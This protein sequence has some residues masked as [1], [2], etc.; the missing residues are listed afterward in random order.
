MKTFLFIIT[1]LFLTVSAIATT[2]TTTGDGN[3]NNA[4]NW[5]ANGSPGT[6][7]GA[8][9]I[10]IINNV[11]TLNV[12]IGYAGSL[13]INAGASLIGN[14]NIS[15]NNGG[16]F[17]ADGEVSIKKL[18]LNS[19]SSM[20]H[21]EPLTTSSD[22]TVGTN[23]TLTSN[24]EVVIGGKL[25]NNGGIIIANDTYDI[26]GNLT[27]NNG[28]I[29]FNEPTTV[30]GKFDNNNSSAVINLNSTFDVTG[31]ITN[32][33]SATINIDSE[34]VVS[35]SGNFTNNSG[36]QVNNDG[37][38]NSSGNFKNNGGTIDSNGIV[39]ID[40]SFTQNG[41]TFSNNGG[42]IVD[43]GFTINGGGTV[44]GDGI[45]RVD[46]ITNHGTFTG[47]VDICRQD[48]STPTTTS[49]SGSYNVAL[50][51]CTETSS[52]AL[53]IILKNFS[54]VYISNSTIEVTWVTSSEINN[55]YFT[56]F[57]SREGT[58]FVKAKTINAAGNNNTELTYKTLI[59]NNESNELYLQLK[60][61]DFDGNF[62]IFDPILVKKELNIK[63]HNSEEVSIFPNP[64]DG[65]T[66]FA[67]F[68]NFK[69]D[70]YQIHI[71]DNNGRLIVNN[72]V[73]IEKGSN[74]LEVELLNGIR[75]EK[76]LHFIRVSS[77]NYVVTRKY[78]VY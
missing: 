6:Y 71:L 37:R 62:E 19:T 16:S 12:N 2:Y 59:E 67:E 68:K 49:G 44:N 54:A 65:A 40:G 3:W 4:S 34:A 43:G 36:S 21:S 46:Q 17:I 53:P 33:S 32:N 22:I 57:Y 20:I 66:I 72:S 1:S 76:G 27:N 30:G 11:M 7:W 74:Y 75:L 35:T 48:D 64:G 18:T 52:E 56:L 9:D 70:E 15:L 13:T 63:T 38:I 29:T 10:V 26:S 58:N 50:T 69:P 77:I 23:S 42:M 14:R 24:A 47:T 5:D 28:T 55:D 39:D 31:N 51:Y 61:T 73:I 41:G 25:N 45:L 8:S 60:Q 78:I